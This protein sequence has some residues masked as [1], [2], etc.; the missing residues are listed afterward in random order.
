MIKSREE[1]AG[2]NVVVVVCGS[3]VSDATLERVRNSDPQ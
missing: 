3:N 1:I 2:K